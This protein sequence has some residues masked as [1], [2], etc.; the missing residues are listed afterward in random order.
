[1]SLM[2]CVTHSGLILIDMSQF[3]ILHA[4]AWDH[5]G[6]MLRWLVFMAY[7]AVR[8][9]VHVVIDQRLEMRCI[10]WY[11]L[12]MT[13]YA[14]ILICLLSNF[15]VFNFTVESWTCICAPLWTLALYMMR[16]FRPIVS[17]TNWLLIWLRVNIVVMIHCHKHPFIWALF[18]LL[19]QY[20]L[21]HVSWQKLFV[22]MF[23]NVM[24][25]YNGMHL[26]GS[27]GLFLM[28]VRISWC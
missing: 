11:A 12:C 8:D 26:K 16:L 24:D 6:W 2:S 23:H 1:M 5:I 22:C 9:C 17:R 21:R 20:V 27:W 10:Y 3:L 4:S 7:P 15:C 14:I 25:I 18:F 28:K 19:H 13:T